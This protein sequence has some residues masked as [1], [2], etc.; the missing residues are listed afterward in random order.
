V[1]DGKFHPKRGKSQK[2]KRATK[3]F[4]KNEIRRLTSYQDHINHTMSMNLLFINE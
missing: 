4:M 2:A 3:K 1:K